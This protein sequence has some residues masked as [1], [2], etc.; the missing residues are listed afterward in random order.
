MEAPGLKRGFIGARHINVLLPTKGTPVNGLASKGTLTIA[1]PVTADDTIV[2]GLKT[3]TFKAGATYAKAQGTLSMATKPTAD[4]TVTIGDYVY[5]FVATPAATG[6]VAIG[7]LVANSQENLVAAIAGDAFNVVHP[8]VTAADFAA[9]AMI[10]T[11]ILPGTD[12]NAIASTETFTDLTDAWDA[13][14]LGTTTA[15]ALLVDGQI[16]IGANEAATKLSIVAA[17]NGTDLVNTAHT[18]VTVVAFATDDMVITAI[19]LGVAGDL[20]ATTQT[21]THASNIFDAATLGTTQAGVDGTP[22][23]AGQAM[24]DASYL[25][26]CLSEVESIQNNNW[27][28]VSLGSVY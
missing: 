24:I 2:I 12:G 17:I 1:E 7:A 16:G 19:L 13:A 18:Q 25:Y 20:I 4:D 6:D 5:T 11:A 27:R 26:Y 9:D 8:L 3:Y 23:A 28:R 21:L 22:G 10:V 14:V 15:G